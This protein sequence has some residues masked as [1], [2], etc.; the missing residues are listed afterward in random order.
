MSSR[1]PSPRSR[2]CGAIW[3]RGCEGR[4]RSF[5]S[6]IRWSACVQ[7][8]GLGHEIRVPTIVTPIDIAKMPV[9]PPSRLVA[10]LSVLGV[11]ENRPRLAIGDVVRLRP[12]SRTA[13]GDRPAGRHGATPKDR[14]GD[15]VQA[16]SHGVGVVAAEAWRGQIEECPTFEVQVSSSSCW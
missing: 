15:Q 9:V 4:S 16:G 6:L 10:R 8:F 3:C 14:E 2:V 5:H 11:M 7:G 13:N 12:P 1:L